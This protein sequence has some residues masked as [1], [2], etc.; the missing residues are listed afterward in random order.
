MNLIYKYMK[1]CS[2]CKEV[3]IRVLDDLGKLW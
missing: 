2:K 3:K 1:V